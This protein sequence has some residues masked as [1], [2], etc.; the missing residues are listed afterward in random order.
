MKLNIFAPAIAAVALLGACATATPYQ[1]AYDSNRGYT[2][3][4]VETNRWMVS[5]FG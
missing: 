5:L 2:E 3:Q 4:K 1:A